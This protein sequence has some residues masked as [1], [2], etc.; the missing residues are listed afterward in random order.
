MDDKIGASS[1]ECL[2]S[3]VEGGINVL[4]HASIASNK[5]AL[6]STSNTENTEKGMLEKPNV[7]M[8]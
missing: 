6:T 5:P 1:E 3:G 2:Y 7:A 8:P 4:E